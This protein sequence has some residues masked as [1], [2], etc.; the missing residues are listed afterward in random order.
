MMSPKN[1]TG[2]GL[3]ARAN[4]IR[5]ERD[6]PG[7]F[8]KKYGMCNLVESGFSSLKDSLLANSV[9]G[10]ANQIPQVPRTSEGSALKHEPEWRV[11]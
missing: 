9:A 1:H 4:M 8:Y 3:G 11:Q 2:H 6:E 5:W 10:H 7:S